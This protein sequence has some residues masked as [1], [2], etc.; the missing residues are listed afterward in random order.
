MTG[1]NAGLMIT[2]AFIY[3]GIFVGMS[4]VGQTFGEIAIETPEEE[5]VEPEDPSWYDGLLGVILFFPL[6][7]W[8]AFTSLLGYV[9]TQNI[10]FFTPIAEFLTNII[11]GIEILP[12]WVNA[13]IFTPLIVGV[14][15]LIIDLVWIG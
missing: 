15:Y 13:I 10:P 6:G 3:M 14:S 5:T 4:F 7:V 9:S 11:L 2:I 12:G 1:T 8:E